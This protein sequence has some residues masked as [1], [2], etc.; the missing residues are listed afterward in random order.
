MTASKDSNAPL[1]QAGE[2]LF[3]FAIEREDTKWLMARLPAEAQ[4]QPATAEYELQ[5]LK[6][7]SVGWSIA[8]FLEE[9]P[10]KQGLETA[11]WEAVREFAQGLST[12]TELMIGE[13]IDYFQTL[14]D[15]LDLYLEALRRAPEASNATEVIG[16]EFACACGNRD[17]LFT[18]FTGSRMFSETTRRVR[19]YLQSLDLEAIAR[20]DV[21]RH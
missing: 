11:F 20:D 19:E 4:I 12:T 15:R 5:I 14:K 9:W 16:P 3:N 1:K 13:D 18:A 7:I 6:I 2:D 10:Q 21:L 17:D 8:Y